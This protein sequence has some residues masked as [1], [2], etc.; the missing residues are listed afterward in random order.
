MADTSGQV[1]IVA[2][3]KAEDSDEIIMRFQERYGQ[4]VGNV[5]TGQG[6]LTIRMGVPILGMRE[7]NAAEEE[8]GP[9]GGGTGTRGGGGRN[10]NAPAQPTTRT[11]MITLKPYQPRAIALKLQPAWEA[12]ASAQ[13]AVP[14]AAGVKVLT[15]SGSGYG[16]TTRTRPVPSTRSTTITTPPSMRATSRR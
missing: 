10:A 4:P 8:V 15:S 14:N 5:A 6:G 12:A 9:F 7:V 2:M 13:A 3:K 16:N 1:A 11:F